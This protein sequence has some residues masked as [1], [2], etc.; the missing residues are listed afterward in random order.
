LAFF[1]LVIFIRQ[2]SNNNFL[3][4]KW[5]K[6]LFGVKH[7]AVK[8]YWR[9]KNFGSK[10]VWRKKISV[11]TFWSEKCDLKKKTIAPTAIGGQNY[12]FC[13]VFREISVGE[14]SVGFL[15]LDGIFTPVEKGPLR[16]VF[17]YCNLEVKDRY[18]RLRDECHV[19]ESAIAVYEEPKSTD[20]VF[21]TH[22]DFGQNVTPFTIFISF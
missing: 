22:G 2:F 19:G 18:R 20:A 16:V 14:I 4:K 10:N 5:P 8:T 12:I 9:T 1:G 13:H 15:L 17:K 6:N 21:S 11:K 7:I 3:E